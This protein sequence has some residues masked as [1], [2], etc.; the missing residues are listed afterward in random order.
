MC[1]PSR[2]WYLVDE[3]RTLTGMSYPQ[4]V[5]VYVV[6]PAKPP[7]SGLAVAGFVFSLLWGFGFLS[8]IGLALSLL[9]I[10]Q[11]K[12]NPGM[13]G[14]TLAGWGIALG[15]LGTLWLAFWVAS[16]I[17]GSAGNAG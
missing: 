8:P 9:A 4:P 3:E 6:A 13:R 7:M 16:F 14:S 5:P 11:I 17:V 15:A 1:H 10:G 12:R 2:P